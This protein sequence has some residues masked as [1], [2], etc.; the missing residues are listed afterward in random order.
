MSAALSVDDP[1]QHATAGKEAAVV[2]AAFIIFG[3][4]SW[5]SINSVF[6]Q[7]SFL[8]YS[9]PEGW[10]LTT[11]IVVAL[12]LANLGALLL[13]RPLVRRAP[14]D[15][16][17]SALLLLL[18][19][20]ASVVLAAGACHS[21]A[22]LFG[23]ERSTGLL[24]MTF[25]A[26]IASCGSSLV[27]YP[28]ASTFPRRYTTALAIGEGLSGSAAG[29]LGML[30]NSGAIARSSTGAF[31]FSAVLG[32]VALLGLLFLDR[33]PYAKLCH[34]PPQ[35]C[36]ESM[37]GRATSNCGTSDWRHFYPS[38]V[39][40]FVGAALNF[41]LLPSLNPLACSHY[42]NSQTV[43]LWSNAVIY[44]FDPVSRLMTAFTHFRRLN[45]LTLLF[46]CAALLVTG[47]AKWPSLA[48]SPWVIPMANVVFA[49]SFG[50]A[51]TMAFLILKDGADPT[52]LYW[53]AGV[54]LQAGSFLGS[55]VSLLLVEVLKVF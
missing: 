42:G 8:V 6:V 55:V 20:C 47:L 33:H 40:V 4:G 27:F 13:L 50:Y 22:W 16:R 32:A 10:S 35:A 51:R 37:S 45:A 48:W 39:A 12:Q 17:T 54:V 3:L 21:T 41:G 25:V 5:I 53:L 49:A 38:F 26:G 43:L 15:W 44:G 28:F 29:V 2:Y 9:Q 46:T 19:V 7:S 1:A 34:E 30:Q 18:G 11:W 31:A 23:A 52:H 36:E 24:T 14:A